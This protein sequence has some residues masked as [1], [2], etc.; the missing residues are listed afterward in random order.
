MA[1]FSVSN[2]VDEAAAVAFEVVQQQSLIGAMAVY[3]VIVIFHVIEAAVELTTNPKSCRFGRG[4]FW[5]RLVLIAAAIASYMT[6]VAPVLNGVAMR[7]FQDFA[8]SWTEIFDSELKIDYQVAKTEAENKELDKAE[9]AASQALAGK[10]PDRGFMAGLAASLLEGLKSMLGSLLALV[11]GLIITLVCLA[12][13]FW[14]IGTNMIL[15]VIGPICI[16]FGAHEKTES[17]LWSFVKST[18]MYGILYLP[19]VAIAMRIASAV[20]RSITSMSI[21]NNLIQGDMMSVAT[22]LIALILGPVMAFAIVK[23]APA[24][25]S[26]V[27]GSAAMG[28]GGGAA[29]FGA[30]STLGS[31][32]RTLTGGAVK[33]A[34]GAVTAAGVASWGVQVAKKLFTPSGAKGGDSSGGPSPKDVRGDK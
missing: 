18:I 20:M 9:Q 31:A 15:M 7:S 11:F 3:S 14:I 25:V 34:S 2:V 4:S 30:H 6:L 10:E 26:S 22:Q 32:G 8:T 17:I 29:A 23:G 19:V 28:S 1:S 16:A 33:A 21:E 12:E 27:F 13:G 5:T 24:A